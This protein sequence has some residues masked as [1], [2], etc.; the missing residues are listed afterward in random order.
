MNF[1][2]TTFLFALLLSTLWIFGLMISY[3]KSAG[4]QSFLM[5]SLQQA[6]AKIDKI[7]V[8]RATDKDKDED[9]V[10]EQSGPESWFLKK[11]DQKVRVE[12]FRMENLLKQIRDAKS[13][14]AADIPRDPGTSKPQAVVTAYG[15]YKDTPKEWKLIIG[16]ESP[17]KAFAYVA[18]S[19]RPEKAFAVSLK[20]LDKILFTN[21]HFMRSKRIF[22]AMELAITS[23][24][25]KK[26]DLE[27]ELQRSDNNAWN[28]V[29][30]PLGPA[31]ES[32]EVEEKK[33]DPH[34]KEPMTPPAVGGV[35][36]LIQNIKRIQVEEDEHFE[37]LGGSMAQ[38]GLE[39]GKESMQI[40]LHTTNDKKERTTETLY[41]GSKVRTQ[42]KEDFYYARFA[43]DDGVMQIRATWLEPIIK[44]IQDPGKL[45]STDIAVFDEKKV[46]AIAIKQGKDDF[47]FFLPG[48]EARWQMFAGSEKKTGDDRAIQFLIQAVQGK[49]AIVEF[50]DFPIAD[51]KKNEAEWGL[52]NPVAE[53]KVYLSALDKDKKE[54]KKDDKTDPKKEVKKDDKDKKDETKAAADA[55][56]TLKAD[57]K[58]IVTLAIGKT[59]K[60]KVYVRRTLEDGKTQSWFT[61]GKEFVEKILPAEGIAIA[62]LDSSLPSFDADL[63]TSIKLQRSTDKGPETLEFV[64][65]YID[66]RAVWYV[67]DPLDPTGAKPADNAT[68][69]SLAL[70]LGK[71]QVKRN[72]RVLGEKEDLD[73]LG[74]KSPTITLTVESKKPLASANA[75]AS[76]VG[77]LIEPSLLTSVLS[78][79]AHRTTD[80]GETVTLQIGKETDNDKDKPAV[81]AK[82]S[83]SKVLFLLPTN[84][85]TDLKRADFHDRTFIIHASSL[86]AG[87]YVAGAAGSPLSLLMLASPQVSGVVHQIDADKVKEVKLEIRTPFEL[88][89]F[90]FVREAKDKPWTD[91][92]N[93]KEFQLDSDKV[94]SVLKDFVKLRTERFAAYTGGPRS[95]HKL[96]AKDATIKLDMTMDDGKT[97]TLNVG[98]AFPGLGYYANS[99]AWPETVFFVPGTLV[100]PLLQGARTFAKERSA[101]E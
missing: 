15:T 65:H 74:L 54:D 56:P 91:K 3:K 33:K 37:P 98:A 5:P 76:L 88:R 51:L 84:V 63:V 87:S 24:Q 64:K 29:K 39:K 41:I 83:G 75:A 100:D 18:T 95:E 47:K 93:L 72:L 52:D 80:K 78:M 25:I 6:D 82:H 26:G 12:G 14:D 45:R 27:L 11:G 70:G 43:T 8:T 57:A 40:D 62:Y 34:G 19:E 2:T 92:S 16:K 67:K 17:D 22:D 38:Y 71:I 73:K 32:N 44:A 59:D 90:N 86:Q 50:N 23:V 4:D 97:I 60:E 55:M 66:N 10:F 96:G 79:V 99:S 42:L 20:N 9:F 89:S 35:K 48:G 77:A 94:N 36:G 46:D 1:R 7:V 21:P 85:V 13:E 58:P 68:V 31:G 30:P 81:Y 61:V 69:A 53:I 101:A 28:F 49:K